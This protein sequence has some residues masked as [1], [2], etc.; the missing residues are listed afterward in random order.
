MPKDATVPWRGIGRRREVARGHVDSAAGDAHTTGWIY[1]G[2]MGAA[3]LGVAAAL[4]VASEPVTRAAAVLAALVLLGTHYLLTAARRPLLYCQRSPLA[5]RILAGCPSLRGR[6]WPTPWCF[7]RHLQLALMAL[8]D[9]REAPL[10]FDRTSRLRL[11]DGGTVSLEWAGLEGSAPADPAPVLI[12]LP[13][14]CGDGWALRRFVRV[15]RTRLGWR[16]VVLNRRGHG[17]LPLTTPRFNTLGS[18]DDLREQLR[19]VRRL[20]PSS[21][22]Y[23][24]GLSAGSGLLVRYLGEEGER[25]PLTAA[26]ALCPGY[27]TTRAFARVHPAYDRYLTGMLRKYFLRRHAGALRS[28]AGYVETLSARSLTA[29]HDRGFH[30]AG[31]SSAGEYHHHTN[32]MLVVPGVRVPLLVLNA[33]DDPV[34]V[35]EN[36]REHVGV[37]DTVAESIIVLTA[38]GSHCAFFEGVLRPASWADRVIAEYLAAVHGALAS[39]A[40]S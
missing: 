19:D 10:C 11:P 22:L 14:I 15:M 27:D 39:P 4:V 29:F 26:V 9:A 13:T 34:C 31:F 28:S 5:E 21:P 33:A 36:V 2:G 25:T 17:D 12:V 7:N 3:A 30:L 24:V 40:P 20:A 8:R 6:F 23:A 18:T 38:R 35:V 37:V 16:V 1:R 32:P